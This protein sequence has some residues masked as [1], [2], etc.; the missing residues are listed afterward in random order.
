V[1]DEIETLDID[2][3]TETIRAIAIAARP[4]VGGEETPTRVDPDRLR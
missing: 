3:V 4:I 2:H 1:T